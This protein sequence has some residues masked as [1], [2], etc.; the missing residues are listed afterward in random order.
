LIGPDSD[1]LDWVLSSCCRNNRKAPF[2]HPHTPKPRQAGR[3]PPK[4]GARALGH[5]PVS[6]G[7]ADV[8]PSKD[9]WDFQG[10]RRG[11]WFIQHTNRLS[12][13]QRTVYSR[14]NRA[15]RLRQQIR[16]TMMQHTALGDV[17]AVNDLVRVSAH[18]NLLDC[19]KVKRGHCCP[20]QDIFRK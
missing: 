4:L 3:R 12:G 2:L 7:S 10:Q 11:S 14:T 15:V 6:G 1:V 20:L 19:N 17:A 8:A 5:A 9:P 18:V 16:K 13:I